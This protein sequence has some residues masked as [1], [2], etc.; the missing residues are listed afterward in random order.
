MS[1]LEDLA[2]LGVDPRNPTQAAGAIA[3]LA[4]DPAG[5]S[6]LIQEYQLASGLTIPPEDVA[7]LT[8]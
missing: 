2:A 8:A 5:R 3:A 1:I 4:A 7:R 6:K